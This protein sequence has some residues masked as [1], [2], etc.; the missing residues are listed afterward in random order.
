[1]THNTD[2]YLFVAFSVSISLVGL[3][4][5]RRRFK[6]ADFARHHEVAGYYLSIVS[7][8]YGILLGL[9]VFNFQNRFEQAKNMA[10]TEVNSLSDIYQIS[11]GFPEEPRHK[12]RMAIRAYYLCVQNEDWEAI[13]TG[14]AKEDS[15]NDYAQLWKAITAFKPHDDGE[16]ECFS[17]ALN[18]MAQFS[19]ARRPRTLSSKRVISPLLWTVLLLGA[20][21][22]IFFTYFFWI[23]NAGI[24]VALTTMVALFLSL[25]LMLLRSYENPYRHEHFLKENTFNYKKDVFSDPSYKGSKAADPSKPAI[26]DPSKS[27]A[28]DPSKP[29]IPDPS[30]P[31]IPDPSKSAIPDPSKPESPDPSKS[32]APDLSKSAAPAN[33][34]SPTKI[35]HQSIPASTSH[36]KDPAPINTSK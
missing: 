4:A 27:E 14:K 8:L 31:A 16:V 17:Q 28:P 33:I 24:Q 18:S 20:T 12:I 26:P 21:L 7:S 5:V 29:A 13:A 1:M 25:T 34:Q 30:K 9:V 32:E 2:L 35:Q 15:V 11:R 6:N 10:E 3:F 19:D 23:E 36:P 22:T